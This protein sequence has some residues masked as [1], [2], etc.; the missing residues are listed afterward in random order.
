V[1]DIKYGYNRFI[2]ATDGPDEQAGF[3]LTALGFPA[4]YN[5][6][7][8]ELVRRFPRFDFTCTTCTGAT[9]GNGHTN[10]F[11]PVGSH[12]VTAVLNR[13]QGK[14]S[15]K[16]GGEMRIYREDDNF[17]S[18][19]QTGQFSFDNTFTRVGSAS[20]ADVEGLGAFAAFLLGYPT[21][22]ALVRS[23]DYSEYSKTYGFFVN[24]DIRLTRKLNIALG[25]R[26]EF[27]TP[28]IERQDKSVSGFDLAYTHPLEAAARANY[29]ALNDTILKT[30]LGLTDISA[31]GGLLFATKDT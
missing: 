5:A 18:N 8:P 12:F 26:W 21:T 4:S 31:K 24:D 22:M 13:T 11:R 17:R 14:H 28:L 27:E 30:T 6:L 15:L 10:E 7:V 9:L 3:D 20:A 2:R 1:L 25:L 19:N 16:F 29:A 23:A